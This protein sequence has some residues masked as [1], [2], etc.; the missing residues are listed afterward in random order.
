MS[1]RISRAFD[2]YARTHAKLWRLISS[3][4]SASPA[5]IPELVRQSC[6]EIA[7]E[8]GVTYSTVFD[9][10]TRQLG[11]SAEDTYTAITDHITAVDKMHT[12]WADAIRYH[13]CDDDSV[14]NTLQ[15]LN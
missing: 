5:V 6:A 7:D 1:V 13:A 9:Q 14:V 2:V 3:N 4:G 11:F 8:D 15:N 10:V 12:K